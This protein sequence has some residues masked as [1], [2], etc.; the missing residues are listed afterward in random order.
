MACVHVLGVDPGVTCIGTAWVTAHG[1]WRGPAACAWAPHALHHLVFGPVGWT[2]RVALRSAAAPKGGAQRAAGERVSLP[3]R[4]ART[5]A[6]TMCWDGA[7]APG[8]WNA[9]V[10]EA[11][12]GALTNP[13]TRVV[14]GAFFAYAA[15]AAAGGIVRGASPRSKSAFVMQLAGA[16]VGAS[17]HAGADA[18]PVIVARKAPR[19][20]KWTFR[21]SGGGG[22]PEE[23][24]VLTQ[25]AGHAAPAIALTPAFLRWV[26]GRMV[27]LGGGGCGGGNAMGRR[28]VATGGGGHLER[29][30][31]LGEGK[32]RRRGR[33][34]V[35][36]ARAANKAAAQSTV[37]LLLLV[38]CAVE[39]V[40][41]ADA[42]AACAL[43]AIVSLDAAHRHDVCD[44]ALFA[45]ATAATGGVGS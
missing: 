8:A 13:G 25:P 21:C 34:D 17:A 36:A 10:V 18:A 22:L 15:G 11:Q 33:D 23:L 26:A 41:L 20:A 9:V 32:R 3:Q 43:L 2:L 27:D 14:E 5:V 42:P 1:D 29:V 37:L 35:G 31:V 45:L 40:L 7:M 19:Q 38:R 4:I 6:A 30:D 39:R 24:G 44:A 28:A 16:L 12:P